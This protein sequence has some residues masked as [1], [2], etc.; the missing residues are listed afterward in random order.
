VDPRVQNLNKVLVGDQVN[1]AY[2]E[3]WA[4][5]RDFGGAIIQT[6]QS[7]QTLPAGYAARTMTI[8]ATVEAIDGGKRRVT[9]KHPPGRSHEVVVANDPR[10]LGRL[11]VGETYDIVYT[12]A[13]AVRGRQGVELARRADVPTLCDSITR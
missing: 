13:L 7:G 5:N 12:E 8:P 9:F 10:I 1:V 2:Y 11:K 6:A 3:S 4:L